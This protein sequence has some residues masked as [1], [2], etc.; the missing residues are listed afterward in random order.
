M[1]RETQTTTGGRKTRTSKTRHANGRPHTAWEEKI[2]PATPFAASPVHH[3]PPPPPHSLSSLPASHG[4]DTRPVI[5]STESRQL[6][7]P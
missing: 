2:V 5:D 1:R 7:T 6:S 3:P 4:W